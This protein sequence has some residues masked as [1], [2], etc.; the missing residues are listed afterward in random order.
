MISWIMDS[1]LPWVL[2]CRRQLSWPSGK[3]AQVSSA[4]VFINSLSFNS[5]TQLVGCTVLLSNL[6]PGLLHASLLLLK[7]I[8]LPDLVALCLSFL[9]CAGKGHP[10]RDDTRDTLHGACHAV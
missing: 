3:A 1:L 6:P 5:H 2:A 10:R 9:S 8:A 4:T 7:H